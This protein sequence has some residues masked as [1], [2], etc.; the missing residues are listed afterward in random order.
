[1]RVSFLM[2][3][4]AALAV[5]GNFPQLAVANEGPQAQMD[6]GNHI[7]TGRPGKTRRVLDGKKRAKPV[8][9]LVIGK[10]GRG[11]EATERVITKNEVVFLYPYTSTVDA[12]IRKFGNNPVV[13]AGHLGDVAPYKARTFTNDEGYFTFRGL[14]PGRYLLMT[15]VPYEV[16]T[17]Q[18]E[19]T[20]KTRT[21][22]SFGYNG[23]F[24][25]SANSVSEPIY[26]Y[27]NSRSEFEHPIVKIVDVRADQ[28]IT[29]MGEVE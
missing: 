22:T 29:A 2:S 6:I 13:I 10:K 9:S 18:R 24:L 14:K 7:L 28:K 26:R 15:A 27:T 20:G 4:A 11:K 12:A 25:D 8:I 21:K 3:A 5:G 19:D 17:T 1:V 16:A 23:W